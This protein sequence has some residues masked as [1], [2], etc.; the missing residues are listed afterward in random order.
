MRKY[1]NEEEMDEVAEEAEKRDR[2]SIKKTDGHEKSD[3]G[4]R[5]DTKAVSREEEIEKRKKEGSPH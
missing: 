5:E 3:R 4:G 1:A 2:E